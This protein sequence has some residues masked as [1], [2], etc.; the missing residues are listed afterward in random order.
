MRASA[1]CAVHLYAGIDSVRAGLLPHLA[2]LSQAFSGSLRKSVADAGIS[3]GVPL[4]E[5]YYSRR[6]R[7]PRKRALARG[8][9][10]HAPPRKFCKKGSS[11]ASFGEFEPLYITSFRSSFVTIQN[12]DLGRKIEPH[13]HIISEQR[14]H[15]GFS[16]IARST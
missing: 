5:G 3:K 16:G 13:P 15:S 12:P 7:L 9:W 11:E 1:Y 6:R 2:S 14:A 8:V 10:V 4:A